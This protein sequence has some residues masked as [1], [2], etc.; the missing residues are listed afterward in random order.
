[1][2]LIFYYSDPLGTEEPAVTTNLGTEVVRFGAVA[3][4]QS[5]DVGEPSISGI[6][7]DDPAGALN[8]VGL[9]A[10]T[11][12]ETSAPSNN[13][14]VFRGAIQDRMVTRAGSMR[15]A[16][17]RLWNMDLVD[18]NWHLGKRILVDHDAKR[19]DETA[20]DRIRWLLNNAAHIALNDY[21]NVHYPSDQMEDSDYRGMRPI[22]VLTDC[23]IETGYNFWCEYNEAH[24]TPE[25]FFL[26]PNGG[27][28]SSDL[29]ISNVYSDYDGTTTF[30]PYEDAVLT[31]SASRIAF[32]V[33]LAYANGSVYVRNDTTGAQFAKVDQSAPMSLVKRAARARRIATHFLNDNDAEDD[34]ISCSIKVPV[35]QVNDIRAGQRLEVKFSHLPGYE[36][37]VYCRVLRRTIIQDEEGGGYVGSS[38]TGAFYRIALEL[39]PTG[40]VAVGTCSTSLAG[41]IVSETTDGTP[42]GSASISILPTD[43]ADSLII[44][45]VCA[46]VGMSMNVTGSFTPLYEADYPIS[47][48]PGFA[49]AYR[50]VTSA[51]GSYSLSAS[52]GSAEGTW[53]AVLAALR[54]SASAPVQEK[55]TSNTL[56]TT[57]TLDSPTTLGN[58]LVMVACS[59]D[60]P[61]IDPTSI[62][63][64]T[65]GGW[66]KI[67][68]ATSHFG[69]SGD[70]IAIFVACPDRVI[71]TS[72]DVGIPGAGHMTFTEWEIT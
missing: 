46:T 69:L 40:D 36:S 70:V 19:P 44:G 3:L 37:F 47:D 65:I 27:S 53:S 21:G 4:T 8:F 56:N 17:A 29:R 14:I 1:M 60:D 10:F 28:Y 34:R 66:T 26:N 48:H 58:L 23:A 35:A 72:E 51:S 54:T 11:V 30:L 61:S 12:K 63:P 59:R 24:Q 62:Q 42:T 15:T 16:A 41:A 50:A 25:L 2:A 6:D 43:N 49:S 13:Q 67:A 31:R 55:S 68:E 45:G 64:T 57:A 5:A 32:G 39:T 22:D 38:N 33:Y 52:Y 7:I 71:E 20:G 18:Y 9:R